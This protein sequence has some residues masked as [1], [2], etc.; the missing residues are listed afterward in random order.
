MKNFYEQLQCNPQIAQ[1]GSFAAFL[2]TVDPQHL[3]RDFHTRN[4]ASITMAQAAWKG[5]MGAL[6][7]KPSELLEQAERLKKSQAGKGKEAF[8]Q[9]LY[10]LTKRMS[11]TIRAIY[12]TT[13]CLADIKEA[14]DSAC[15][16][17][18]RPEAFEE[19]RLE[20][21][22]EL[23]GLFPTNVERIATL[24]DQYLAWQ[25]GNIGQII[26]YH[27]KMAEITAQLPKFSDL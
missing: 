3:S 6:Y 14:H 16:F 24:D 19:N 1:Y 5:L 15:R 13:E 27:R 25:T 4:E 18:V 9:T 2:Y 22:Q 26:N 21:L 17:I 12:E 8:V 23:A 11:K 7:Q 10:Q 20:K